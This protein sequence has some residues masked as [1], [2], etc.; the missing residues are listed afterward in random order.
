MSAA[1]PPG[2]G[3]PVGRFRLIAIVTGVGLLVLSVGFVLKRVADSP[4]LV[5]VVGPIHG[6]LYVLYLLATVDLW[7]LRRWSVGRA[8]LVA[9]AGT[10]PFMSFVAERRIAQDVATSSA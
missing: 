6:F 8:V 10:V 3:D 7:R 2:L 1:P 5:T 4:G 9:L